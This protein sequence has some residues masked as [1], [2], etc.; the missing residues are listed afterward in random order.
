[1]SNGDV[2]CAP[3]AC[4]NGGCPTFCTTDADCISGNYCSSNSCKP[5]LPT[6]SACAESDECAS[7]VCADGVCCSTPC[8]S[9][10]CYACA[11]ADGATADGT[12]TPLSGT[13]CDDGNGCTT[14]DTC[15]SG[16]CTPV[17]WVACPAIDTCHA[18]GTCDPASGTCPNVPLPDGTSCDDGNLCTQRDTCLSGVCVGSD[19]VTC[20]QPPCGPA[21]ACNP[22][23]GRCEDAPEAGTV[24]CADASGLEAATGDAAVLDAM[25]APADGSETGLPDQDAAVVSVGAE[26]EGS[27][28]QSAGCGCDEAPGA[29]RPLSVA[30][31]VVAMGTILTRRRARRCR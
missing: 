31:A 7:G 29:P 23:T 13:S 8:S 27:I 15:Q 21:Q 9:D 22:T 5:A 1:M 4:E 30:A 19:P 6:G 20:T 28:R 25:P 2:F 10:G 11:M 26:N 17:G 18:A 16:V 12:C 3:Y 14:G 24:L